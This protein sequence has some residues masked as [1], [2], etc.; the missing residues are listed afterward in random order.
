MKRK[1][2]KFNEKEQKYEDYIIPD[3]WN[4]PL[5]TDNMEEIIN[6][7]QCGK[8]IRYG[9]GYTSMQVHNPLGLGYTVCEECHLKEYQERLSYRSKN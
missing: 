3:E 6:C 8:E 7:C 5:C 2:Q 1:Y 9:D 4:V